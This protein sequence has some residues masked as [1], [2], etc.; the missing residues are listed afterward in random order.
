MQKC[1]EGEEK[2]KPREILHKGCR[3]GR[4]HILIE[5]IKVTLRTMRIQFKQNILDGYLEKICP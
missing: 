1:M 5:N 2:M 4:K 3:V